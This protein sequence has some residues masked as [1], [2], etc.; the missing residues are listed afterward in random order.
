M[1]R[2]KP[3]APVLPPTWLVV[4]LGNPGPEYSGTRH[5]IGFEIIDALTD[6]AGIKLKERRYQAVFGVAMLDSEPVV[7]VKPM[8]FMNL[9]GRAVGPLCQQFR[10][11]PERVLIIADD[12]DL[13]VG[14]VRLRAKG[15]P[16]GHNGHKSVVQVLGTQEYP[17]IKV[18]VGK[19]DRGETIDHVLGKFHPDER[20]AIAEAVKHA[21]AATISVVNEGIEPAMNRFNVR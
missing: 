13:P 17:R 5:N 7:L 11:K 10:I 16:G 21:V 15:S 2:K 14:A 8:T 18:G 3:S 4:G 6:Q 1:F 19:T 20:P 12:L 9:S